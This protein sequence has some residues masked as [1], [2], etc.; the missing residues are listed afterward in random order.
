MLA[1]AEV[2]YA[3]GVPEETSAKFQATYVW[4]RKDP[5]T[6]AYSG[7]HS[8]SPE[9]ERSYSFTATAA[10]GARTWKGGETYFDPEVTHGAPLSGLTGLGGFTNGEIART[11]G[12]HLT[13]YRAR[14]FARQTW[15]F[16]GG[17]EKVDSDA[18][19]LA[20]N[21]D[22]QRLVLTAGNLSVLDIFDDNA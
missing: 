5:F 8:L 3:Q 16:G 13:F 11:S 10:L 2:G 12:P 14:L 1:L 18:N 19:Q 9:R 20:G 21:A 7:L 6:A 15:G 22:R 4:H 17:S